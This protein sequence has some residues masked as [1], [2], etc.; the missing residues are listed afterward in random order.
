M[1]L[2]FAFNEFEKFEYTFYSKGYTIRILSVCNIKSFRPAFCFAGK[3]WEIHP[4]RNEIKGR[5][6]SRGKNVF[7]K[8]L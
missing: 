4:L 7:S 3:K 1:K 2:F 6:F 5:K 8:R